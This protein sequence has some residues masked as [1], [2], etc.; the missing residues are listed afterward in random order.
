MSQDYSNQ[1]NTADNHNGGRLSNK[2]W[3]LVVI[4]AWVTV[5]FFVA[6]I[7]LGGI[8]WVA[9]TLNI[10]LETLSP[11]ILNTIASVVVYIITIFFV[12]A[13]PWKFK[14]IK[15]N[16]EEVGLNRLPNWLDILLAPAGLISYLALS[17]LLI[18]LATHILPGFDVNQIQNTGF[19]Q[20]SERY[21]Y[22]LA[23]ATLVVIAP[24]AE[25]L[26]FRGYLY[27]KLKKFV[28]LW[29]AVLFTSLLFGVIHGEWNVMIDT[30]ALSIILCILRELTGNIWSSILL[31]MLK[32]GIAF[33]ILFIYP[34]LFTTLVK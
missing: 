5:C 2:W 10:R 7:L 8:F 31:H 17:A 33:F 30:F 1:L 21:Q 22:V 9:D 16:R 25:E 6:Q 11:S 19:N 12:I 15:T 20:L 18:L 3:M 28:P 24:V 26:L 32:N 34:T 14:K 29:V 4:P 27:G 13:L 23:F